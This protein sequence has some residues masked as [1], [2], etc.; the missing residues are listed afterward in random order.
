MT[1]PNHGSTTSRTGNST[2]SYR[3]R[4]AGCS[5]GRVPSSFAL[6]DT[7]RSPGF[8]VYIKNEEGDVFSPT[9]RPVATNPEAW[10]A[11]HAPGCSTF[12]AT[13]KGVRAT[14]SCFIMPNANA[15]VWDVTLTNEGESDRTLDFT[16]Y[17]EFSQLNWRDEPEY[18]YYIKLMVKTW[19]DESTN[20]LQYLYHNHHPRER[21]IP[22]VY[23]ASSEQ[24]VSYAGDRDAFMGPY[25]DERDPQAIEAR[26]AGNAVMSAGEPCGALHS[27]VTLAKGETKRIVY[28]TGTIEGGCR[29]IDRAEEERKRVV[30]LLTSFAKVDEERAALTAWWEKHFSVFSCDIP[31]ANAKRQINVWS[32]VNSVHTGR[33]SRSINTVAPGIRGIGFRDS[34]QD[35]I[36][37]AYRD[38]TWARNVFRY[39]LTQQFEDGHAVHTS[40]PEDAKPPATSVHS[41][42][43]LW[44]PL[45]AHAIL[46]ETHDLSL[47]DEEV[48]FLSDDAKGEGPRAT[49]WDHLLAT[50]RFTEAN[51]GAHGLPLTHKSDWNDIIGR[52]NKHGKG[53]TVFAGEQ[54]VLALR[55]LLAI[56]RAK[57]DDDAAAFLTECMTREL[58]ALAEHAWDGAWWRRGFDDEGTPVGSQTSSAGNIFVNPQSW[59]VL[60]NIGTDEQQR[61][62]MDAAYDRLATEFGLTILAPSFTS[63]AGESGATVGYGPGC[64][65]NGAIF[66]HANTWAIMAE[67]LLGNGERAWTYFTSVLPHNIIEKIGVDRYQAE[68]YAWVSNIIGPENEKYGLGNVTQITG[69]AAWMDVAV[70]QYI[71]GVRPTLEGL[72]IAPAIPPAWDEFTV[73]RTYRKAAFTIHVTNPKHVSSGVTCMRINGET[74]EGNVVPDACY[75]EGAAHT[76]EVVL[77]EE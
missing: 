67:A 74:V 5:G 2:R 77:G 17:T 44:L 16:G 38:P 51:L 4:V 31:D 29:D 22:L 40:F 32:P 47:L 33:Y 15:L 6:R 76:I 69:T 20:S 65:E 50:A 66:C 59:A 45:L 48:P 54:Y 21:E 63:W 61:K 73:K 64:G 58:R 41:D 10:S 70:T 49:V 71:L 72:R 18:G 1:F 39:L 35:M 9:K 25:R 46:A 42:D 30:P 19:F 12:Y 28:I 52:F 27:R 55:D 43:H 37:I 34:C 8:Y 23:F 11:E 75:E 26:D 24:V 7:A 68:P 3:K 62:G 13:Y 53:E 36:A 56:A 57:G 60:A 14:E